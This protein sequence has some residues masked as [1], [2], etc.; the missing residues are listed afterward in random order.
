MTLTPAEIL[1]KCRRMNRLMVEVQAL[2]KE[3]A[4]NDV[5]VHWG[6]IPTKGDP[7][8]QRFKVVVQFDI[9]PPPAA[10]D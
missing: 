4:D 10:G 5:C 8:G 6:G 2:G 1:K 3:L 7:L 9:D